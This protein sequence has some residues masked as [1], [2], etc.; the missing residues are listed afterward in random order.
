MVSLAGK[1]EEG[2]LSYLGT[3]QEEGLPWNMP[4]KV[5]LSGLWRTRCSWMTSLGVAYASCL[6]E[7]NSKIFDA[8][9]SKRL[10]NIRQGGNL[11]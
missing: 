7:E 8:V 2:I 3:G 9:P 10:M 6:S 5:Y 1:A 4:R 11:E